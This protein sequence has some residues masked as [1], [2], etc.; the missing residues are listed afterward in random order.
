M[1]SPPSPQDKSP[2]VIS[3]ICLLQPTHAHRCL[4][5]QL[6]DHRTRS[7]FCSLSAILTSQHCSEHRKKLN[8]E[9]FRWFQIQPEQQ[10]ISR[11]L[12]SCAWC[13]PVTRPNIIQVQ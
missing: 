13:V 5:K 11:H 10:P 1:L 9:F 8:L 2:N 7:G 3:S 6:W 4:N 12:M